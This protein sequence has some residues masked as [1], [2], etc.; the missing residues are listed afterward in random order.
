VNILI[1]DDE[2][3]AR[4]RLRFMLEDLDG[5]YV[6][7]AEAADGQAAVRRCLEQAVDLVLMDIRMPGLSGLE[8]AGR[9]AK[10]STPPAVIF[11]TAYNEHALDA[12]EQ[13]AIDYLVKPVRSQRLAQA[14]QRTRVL[15]RPQLAAVGALND[16]EDEQAPATTRICSRYRGGLECVEVQDVIYFRAEQ[17]YVEAYHSQGSLLLEDS[18][19]SL[20]DAYG[21]RFLRIHRNA[22]VARCRLVGIEKRA[23]CALAKLRGSEDM[24]EISRRHLPEVRAWLKRG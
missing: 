10:M 12:F 3:L 15:T 8:A 22:L 16:D 2:P 11:V 13:Q 17:K 24:L 18:L 21:E 6:V 19:K 4:E 7:V 23:G 14:L 5:G 9:L 1:A 20:E